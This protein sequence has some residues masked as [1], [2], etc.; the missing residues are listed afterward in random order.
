MNDRSSGVWILTGTALGYT[1][2]RRGTR[3]MRADPAAREAVSFNADAGSADDAVDR[4]SARI[5]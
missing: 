2:P 3:S 5:F 4:A 1:Q